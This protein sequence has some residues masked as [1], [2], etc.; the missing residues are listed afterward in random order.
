MHSRL[1]CL[2][3]ETSESDDDT[4]AN[5]GARRI[6]DTSAVDAFAWIIPQA[7]PLRIN[8]HLKSW[9]GGSVAS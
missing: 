1:L 4:L 8:E 5:E 3:H 2:T 6:P 9:P 7:S